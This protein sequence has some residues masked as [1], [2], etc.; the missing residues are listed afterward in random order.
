MLSTRYINA[1]LFTF[2]VTVVS[3]ASAG[4]MYKWQD[5]DGVWHFSSTPPETD[6]NFDTVE[7][8]ADPK[9]MIGM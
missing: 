2:L 1:V 4:D 5:K 8:P 6:E 3:I 9:P 7:M